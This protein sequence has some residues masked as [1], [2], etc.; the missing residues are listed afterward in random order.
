MKTAPIIDSVSG[1]QQNLLAWFAEN[2]RA[3][4]WRETYDPYH[5][6]ISEIMGQQTQM[7]R[8]VVYFNRW[9]EQFPDILAVAEA[10]EQNILKCWEGLGYYSRAT[11]IHRAAKVLTRRYGGIIPADYRQLLSLP[12]IGP[13]TAAAI[14]SIAYNHPLPV[15]DANVERVFA[16]L[17]D[18]EKPVKETATRRVLEQFADD[19]L[20]R[21]ES[22]AFNQALMELGA[23]VCT[24][25]NPD[26]SDCPVQNQ[27]NACLAGTVEERPVAGKKQKK[28]EIV[29]ACGIIRQDNLFYI[30]QRMPGD[31]WAR[32]WEFPGGRLKE[33]ETPEQA[34]G[35]EVFEETEFRVTELSPFAVVVHHYTK[36]RVTL[37]AFLC[38]LD[39]LQPPVLHAA[40]GYRWVSLVE[41]ADFPFPAGHRQLVARLF[42]EKKC[43]K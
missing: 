43:E 20:C 33:R 14:M 21:E 2:Q 31:V 37:H 39:Q 41:L 38:T 6:W 29:M 1:F 28:I 22:R 12:G 23:L 27:C 8:V 17:A 19:L 40:T 3:L 24:P 11:N 7:D 26:C 10:S 18:I 15:I 42:S 34:A 5:V 36:Y 13:Y 9:I 4:P 35:R 30:Q 25:R 32:L 16:R